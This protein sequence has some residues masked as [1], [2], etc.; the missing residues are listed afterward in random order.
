MR[1]R[2]IAIDFET[3]N[4]KRVSA[5]SV[6][7]C[8]IEGDAITESFSSFIKPPLEFG[9]FAPI[10]MRVHG[11]T[12]DKVA[13]APTFEE[14]FP[15]FKARVDGNIVVSYSKFDLS[16]INSLLDY[17]GHRSRFEHIDVCALAK[18][19]IPG[20]SNYKLPTVAKHFGLGEF[21]HHDAVSDAVMCA[22]VFL[23]LQKAEEHIVQEQRHAQMKQPF[24]EAFSGFASAIVEDGVVDYKEAVELMCFL[25]ILPPL[26]GVA[27]LRQ[28]VSDFLEDG[29]ISK[30]ESDLLI[31]QLGIVERQLLGKSF[32]VCP[33]CGGPKFEDAGGLCPWCLAHA[34]KGCEISDEADRHL[35][36]IASAIFS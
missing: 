8:V 26:D 28:N 3:A 19:S 36:D 17:Y 2:I 27:R 14:L 33:T 35:D 13:D 23:S 25:E 31:A 4:P 20:L 1:Q 21:N 6:G 15:R 22:K 29:E 16:V 30:E 9:D 10:N 18:R 5:C 12:P 7:G 24:A 34:E 32:L 11:I